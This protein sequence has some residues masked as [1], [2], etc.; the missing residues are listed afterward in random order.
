MVHQNAVSIDEM[1]DKLMTIGQVRGHLGMTEP[2]SEVE[3]DASAAEVR[4]EDGW[5]DGADT[6]LT[7]AYLR[8]PG[9]VE[10]QLTKQ[11]VLE[12]GAHVGVP[13]ELQKEAPPELISSFVNGMLGVRYADKDLKMLARGGNQVLAVTRAT[14]SPFSNIRLLDT[15]LA[16]IAKR[17]G[18][19]EVLADYKFHHTLE[20]TAMRLIVPGERRVITGTGVPD[21]TWSVGIDFANSLTGTGKTDIR[22]YL[23]RWWCTNGCIDTLNAT[24]AFSRRGSTEDD[25]VAWAAATVEEVL[26]GLEPMLDHVQELTTQPVAG[27]VRD[28]LEGLFDDNRINV[29]DRHRVI[30]EMADTED[31]TGYG[32]LNAITV[33]A[34]QDGLDHRA[35]DRLMGMGGGFIGSHSTRCN[36]GR[37]HRVHQ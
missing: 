11:A 5:K 27:D 19:G 9:G 3:F 4:Y 8:L 30:A 16:G 21:D 7:S 24:G 33:T 37:V 26:G 17:Y 29:R 2:L 20:N 34:N 15:V 12:V 22:G 28:T 1:R 36:L 23:F 32:L 13:R 35:V 25:A 18:E 6:D 31:M 10:Y 14:V